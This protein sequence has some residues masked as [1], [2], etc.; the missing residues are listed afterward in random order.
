MST[1]PI[2]DLARRIDR[3]TRR[4]VEAYGAG[5]IS[6]EPDFTSRLVQAIESE[7]NDD[8]QDQEV[9]WRGKVLADRGRG[10]EEKA[11]GA[12]LLGVASIG[13]A[14]HQ[15]NKGFL[16]Q[17]KRKDPNRKW[18]GRDKE[19]LVAQCEKMLAASPD[20]FVFLYS[21]TGVSVI[22]A[23]SVIRNAAEDVS[24]LH[25]RG[26]PRF[27]EEHM[28]CFIGDRELGEATE[29]GV[30]QI[31]ERVEARLALLISYREVSE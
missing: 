1:V 28:S 26:L 25:A 13:T 31:R 7:V 9:T 30:E 29:S 17:A 23:I 27:Y 16:A 4:V 11:L 5:R 22:P 20:S 19:D 12:D 21:R 18:T 6:Q 8:S 15:T 2:R 24:L 3:A 14:P 10:S